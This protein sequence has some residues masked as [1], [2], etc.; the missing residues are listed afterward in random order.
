MTG[1]FNHDLRF[2]VELGDMTTFCY[3]YCNHQHMT[4]KGKTEPRTSSSHQQP[5][6][7]GED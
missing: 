6:T 1:G 7:T 2:D 5:V 3:P 4:D